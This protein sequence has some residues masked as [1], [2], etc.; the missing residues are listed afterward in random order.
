MIAIIENNQT[1]EG[2]IKIPKVLQKYM[3][4]QTEIRPAQHKDVERVDVSYLKDRLDGL[5]YE[6]IGDNNPE[7]LAFFKKS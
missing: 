1:K 7:T 2:Y 5:Q 3:N 4:G 6:S